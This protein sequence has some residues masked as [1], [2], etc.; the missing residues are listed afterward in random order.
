VDVEALQGLKQRDPILQ[1]RGFIRGVTTRW[2]ENLDEK[3]REKNFDKRGREQLS[4]CGNNY[5]TISHR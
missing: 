2:N 5:V 4:F 3:K 1:R